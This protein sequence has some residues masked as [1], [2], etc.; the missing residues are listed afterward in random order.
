M[1]VSNLDKSNDLNL[2]AMECRDVQSFKRREIIPVKNNMLWQLRVGAVRTFTLSEDGSMIPLGFWCVGDMFGQPLNCIQPF[3]IECLTDVKVAMFISD[4]CKLLDQ[5]ML[6]HIYQM[7]SLLVIRHGQV[8]QRLELFLQWLADKFGCPSCQGQ[9]ILLR[10]THQD[11]ADA[12]GT[13]RVTVTRLLQELEKAQ[14]ISWSQ[15]RQIV[16][17]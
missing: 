3:M 13:T 4:Q 16:L 1:Y 7:Q 8:R 2:P 11:M 14:V 15:Q 10:L 12:I 5:A 6:S 17:H 9:L